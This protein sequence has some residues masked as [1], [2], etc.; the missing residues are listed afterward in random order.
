MAG[1]QLLCSLSLKGPA[2]RC[3]ICIPRPGLSM[4][5]SGAVQTDLWDGQSLPVPGGGG[6]VLWQFVH[7]SSPGWMLPLHL[8]LPLTHRSS[9]GLSFPKPLFSP[10][11]RV[12]LIYF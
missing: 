3:H 4:A 7:P 1:P 2:L 10:R 6:G 9:H 12:T 11:Y 5:L 8:T